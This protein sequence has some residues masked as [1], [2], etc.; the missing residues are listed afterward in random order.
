MQHIQIFV[1][2]R[3]YSFKGGVKERNDIRIFD[4]VRNGGIIRNRE[5]WAIFEK[6]GAVQEV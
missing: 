1:K 6:N 2:L 4:L 3:I 5:G